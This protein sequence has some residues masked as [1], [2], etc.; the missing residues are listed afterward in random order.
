MSELKEKIKRYKAGEKEALSE[1]LMQMTPLVKK[2]AAKVHFME[3]E[4]VMQEFYIILLR[5]ILNM[6]ED[7]KEGEYLQYMNK[8]VVNGYKHLCRTHLPESMETLSFE[9]LPETPD[10]GKSHDSIDDVEL[11]CSL[12]NLKNKN[13]KKWKILWLSIFERL[14]DADIGRIL[15]VSRQ[16]VNMEKKDLMKKL[17]EEIENCPKSE[18]E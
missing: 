11:L 9:T 8:A 10:E 15:G 18:S 5:C 2:Y 13:E 14:S 17:L 7:K 4:D 12:E 16:Y 6:G 1:I 3:S